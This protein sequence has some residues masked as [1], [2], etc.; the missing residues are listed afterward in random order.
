MVYRLPAAEKSPLDDALMPNR[1]PVPGC[2][3]RSAICRVLPLKV[4]G[5]MSLI[6][7]PL[8]GLICTRSD[9]GAAGRGGGNP[10]PPIMVLPYST[11]ALVKANPL[12]LPTPDG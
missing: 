6:S 11:P 3:A 2:T 4:I 9:V 12:S 10:L 1:I 8:A 5:P 7:A